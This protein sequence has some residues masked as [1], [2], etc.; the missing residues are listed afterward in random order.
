M[1]VKRVKYPI[2]LQSFKAIREGGYVYVDKTEIA[3]NL[4]QDYKYVFLA[5]PRRFGKSLLLS[6]L[7]SYFQGDRELFDGLAIQHLE[8]DWKKHPVFLISFARLDNNDPE[9]VSSILKQ[10]FQVW[11][12]EYGI[13][14]NDKLKLGPRFSNLIRIAHK[15]SG[16]KVVVLVDEYDNPLINT[17]DNDDFHEI[18][19][20]LLKSVYTNLKDLDEYIQFG[21]LTGVSRFT[22]LSL[23]SGLNNLT[24]VS[25][26]SDYSTI[27]GITQKEF[28]DNFK[29][30]I[31]KF[32]EKEKISF[33]EAI[34]I[35][36]QNYDGYHFSENLVDIYNPYS[37]L[38]ALAS[39]KIGNFWFETATPTFLIKRIHK[40]KID[41]SFLFN[42]ETG[43][44]SL[45]SE[46]AKHSSLLA[47]LFQTG[48]LTIK[49]HKKI[50]FRDKYL[51]GIPNREV[52]EGLM[53]G[54]AKE[55][56]DKDSSKILVSIERMKDS[57]E[58][59]E[60]EV[61]LRELKSYFIGIPYNVTQNVTE[62]FFENNT[63]IILNLL[64][65]YCNA[66]Y[67]TSHGRIDLLIQTDEYVYVIEMKLDG[68]PKEALDQIESKD[69]ALPFQFA[70]K[71]IF[72]IGVNFSSETRNIENWI[73][74]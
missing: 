62:L 22:Q 36:K 47:L 19:K 37:L 6:T 29:I 68:S 50:A 71:K 2:G 60:P 10:Q 70:D 42:Q 39:S 1:E 5:R 51:L 69:Y 59:G 15:V 13:V 74:K 20:S 9:S 73:I 25:L 61:F 24:D 26:F 3:Y 8:K 35:F 56:Q 41:L 34:D 44:L 64:G 65:I 45:T 7:K 67:V 55:Y 57:L 31:S 33:E 11:E 32:A 52:K 14:D 12:E 49:D 38:N 4:T 17:L 54:L 72:K 23:F 66:E 30:G 16:E 58:S 63:Y 46:D 27:C 21:M 53:Y 18:N 28:V 48:Y 43:G 40:E